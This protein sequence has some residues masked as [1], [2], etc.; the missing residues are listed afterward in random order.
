M[1]MNPEIKSKWLAALRSGE[2]E[3]A[4][5]SLQRERSRDFQTGQIQ[6]GFCCLGVLCDLAAQE[7]VCWWQG[8]GAITS[9][10][11][12]LRFDDEALP[13]AVMDWAGLEDADPQVA[14]VVEEE[15]QVETLSKLN[16]SYKFDFNRIASLIEEHL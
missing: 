1:P 4:R 2:Y 8:F 14:V 13:P 16:D 5:G 10:S 15:E 7:D 11:E 9:T 3:Q 6:F 12:G